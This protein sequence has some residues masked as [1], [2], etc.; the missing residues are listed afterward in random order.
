MPERQRPCPAFFWQKIGV[1]GRKYLFKDFINNGEEKKGDPPFIIVLKNM[2]EAGLLQRQ[3][4]M[5]DDYR[6]V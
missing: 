6:L 5:K 4:I 1:V 3:M 2:E